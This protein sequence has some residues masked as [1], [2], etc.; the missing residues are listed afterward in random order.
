MGNLL[1]RKRGRPKGS[2]S[3][4]EDMV[5]SHIKTVDMICTKCKETYPITTTNP[6]LYTK[7]VRKDWVCLLCKG[8]K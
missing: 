1:K 8:G 2:K 7:E 3:K 5:P 4:T 6:E